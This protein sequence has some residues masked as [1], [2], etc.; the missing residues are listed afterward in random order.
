LTTSGIFDSKFQVTVNDIKS[1]VIIDNYLENAGSE[2]KRISIKDP[3][4]VEAFSLELKGRM[5]FDVRVSSWV[6]TSS[7]FVEFQIQIR[8]LEGAK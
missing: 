5:T 6:K 7:N 1:A 4:K 8:Y 2:R 3:V